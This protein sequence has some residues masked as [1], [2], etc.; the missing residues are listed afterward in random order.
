MAATPASPHPHTAASDR[1]PT[2]PTTRL[3]V[4]AIKGGRNRRLSSTTDRTTS[5][6]YTST[7][8]LERLADGDSIAIDGQRSDAHAAAVDLEGVP[9][10]SSS[11]PRRIIPTRSSSRGRRRRRRRC[12][13]L[14]PSTRHLRIPRGCSSRDRRRTTITGRGR[15]LVPDPNRHAPRP[16]ESYIPIAERILHYPLSE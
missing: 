15:G 3:L 1:G 13:H 8:H 11:F 4:L 14:I 6:A 7:I 5:P 9:P 12:L 10:W 2:L 16:K